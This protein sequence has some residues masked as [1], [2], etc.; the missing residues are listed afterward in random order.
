MVL[1]SG[2]VGV[3]L[4]FAA[5]V[6]VVA[7]RSSKPG[8]WLRSCTETLCPLPYF[9]TVFGT[10]LIAL[11]LGFG[12]NPLT[13]KWL[14]LD[15]T[16][17]EY[18]RYQVNSLNAFLREEYKSKRA[19]AFTLDDGK[20]YIAQVFAEPLQS[21]R[22]AYVEIL[23]RWSGYRHKE[24]REVVRTRDYTKLLEAVEAAAQTNA[25]QGRQ[26]LRLL[27]VVVPFS[28]LVSIHGF[29]DFVLKVSELPNYEP[30]RS[31]KPPAATERQPR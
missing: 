26:A 13:R 8:L 6:F 25:E 18:Q 3:L 4:V 30:P 28:R 2:V 7:I 24:T 1:W 10:A 27:R 9:G 23:P 5:R 11:A 19:L 14:W 12:L 31:D 16:L 15:K 17:D 22:E 29:D 21:P 20:V